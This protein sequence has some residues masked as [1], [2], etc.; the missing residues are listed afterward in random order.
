[1]TATQ[2]SA[3]RQN[4]NKVPEVTGYFW[5]IKVLCTTVGDTLAD[6]L[7]EELSLGLTKT[8]RIIG[9]LFVGCLVAQFRTRRDVPGLSWLA[10]VLISVVGTLITDNPTDNLG[11]SL[12]TTTVVF[13]I[14]LVLAFGG[15]CASERTLS[16]HSIFTFRG[17]SWYWLAL[18]ITFALGTAAGDLKGRAA[19]RTRA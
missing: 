17:V 8:S 10:V 11:V 18:L 7:N 14:V 4:L 9:G 6:N 1:M 3:H 5:L 15:W 16:I 2:Q 19:T 13:T 12:I